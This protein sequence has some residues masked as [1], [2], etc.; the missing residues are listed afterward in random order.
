MKKE[1]TIAIG[2]RWEEL[3][4]QHLMAQ[5]LSEI[6]RNYRCRMGEIDLVMLDKDQLVFVEVRYRKNSRFASA[7]ESVSSQKQRKLTQ[8][9]ALFL[10]Q[11]PKYR[12]HIV[13]FD[14]VAFDA[15]DDERS[16]LQW[17]HDAFRPEG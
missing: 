13:R 14:V 6:T 15:T 9:A 4:L 12:H 17:L 10:A 1:T 8:T 2:D 3:A 11:Y 16:R 5:G 7:A